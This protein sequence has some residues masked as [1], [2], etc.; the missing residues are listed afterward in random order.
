[1][2][3]SPEI[4]KR[5]AYAMSEPK[6]RLFTEYRFRPASINSVIESGQNQEPKRQALDGMSKR[7]E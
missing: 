7:Q 2:F 1:M 6:A 5:W 4:R 3:S